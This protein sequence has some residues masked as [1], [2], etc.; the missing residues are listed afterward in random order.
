M[1][2]RAPQPVNPCGPRAARCYGY[3]SGQWFIALDINA[4]FVPGT[5][6]RPASPDTCDL[7]PTRVSRCIT[8]CITLYEVYD[9]LYIDK[10]RIGIASLQLFNKCWKHYNNI[11]LCILINCGISALVRRSVYTCAVHC[12]I[13]NLYI[14]LLSR[15]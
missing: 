15:F 13:S 4:W 10:I 11:G 3:L 7:V 9:I 2:Q 8:W 1:Q 6:A 5:L 14:I 12:I